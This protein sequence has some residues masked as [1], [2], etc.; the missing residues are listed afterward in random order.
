MRVAI[1][2]DH[3]SFIGGGE[4]LVLTL[5]QGLDADVYVT[6]LDPAIPAKAGFSAA[7]IAQLPE[8]T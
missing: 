8:N 5:A 1:L 3:M 4:R 2:H 6:D 7:A